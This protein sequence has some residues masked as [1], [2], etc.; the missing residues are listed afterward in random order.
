M[1]IALILACKAPP[2]DTDTDTVPTPV[3]TGHTGDTAVVHTGDT[4]PDVPVFDCTSLQTAPFQSRRVPGARAYHGLAFDTLGNLVGSDG[5]SL[6]R[7]AGSNDASLW[8]PNSS[9]GQ[10]MD[11]LPDGDLVFAH[12]NGNIVRIT[13]AGATTVIASNV[14][15]YG[16]I[17]GPDGFIY[18]AN[19]SVVNR[20]DPVTGDRSVYVSG[21]S[22]PKVINWSP[23]LDRF[24]IGT[25]SSGG[26]VYEVETDPVTLE[27][28]GSPTL[29]ANT[30]N[31][32]HDAL[33]V[34]VCGNLYV[35]EFWDRRLWRIT[36]D[37]DASILVQY[38]SDR[39][40]HGLVWGSGIGEWDALA[41]YVPQPYD[42]N[43][44]SEAIIGIP[45]RR[46]NAGLYETIH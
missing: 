30:S 20:I 12:S 39:Y 35:A 9:S 21:V 33:G 29:L 16:V 17:V 38:P 13:P 1:L 42:N 11:Y 43:S 45:D 28:L 4:G 18:T 34:D 10:Q 2:T 32:W 41:V 6:I 27:P 7:V 26:A 19:Q 44:V 5:S 31:S 36:P 22:V 24:Y 46:F 3:H 14:N 8:V 25:N 23:G 40:G 15:A 37:G